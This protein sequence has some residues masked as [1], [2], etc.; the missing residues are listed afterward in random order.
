MKSLSF[1][2]HAFELIKLTLNYLHIYVIIFIP[3]R[4]FLPAHLFS[5]TVRPCHGWVIGQYIVGIYDFQIVGNAFPFVRI[6]VLES[7]DTYS[8]FTYKLPNEITRI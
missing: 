3:P 8:K 1:E 5:D 2:S 7:R 4:F 6:G